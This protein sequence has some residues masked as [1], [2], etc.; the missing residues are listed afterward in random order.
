MNH[1]P[2]PPAL[3]LD[4]DFAG[5]IALKTLRALYL[6]AP[7]A[8]AKNT[9]TLVFSNAPADYPPVAKLNPLHK[10]RILVTGVS[11]P[12]PPPPARPPARPRKT[13]SARAPASWAR[14]WS[15]ASC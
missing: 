15:T 5:G 11:R 10:K 8:A 2:A 7:A 4:L 9:H 1:C 3:A 14:T 6:A 13:D 12:A